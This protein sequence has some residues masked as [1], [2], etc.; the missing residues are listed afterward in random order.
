VNRA[1]AAGGRSPALAGGNHQ[2]DDRQNTTKEPSVELRQEC[3]SEE[4]PRPRKPVE[5]FWYS[6]RVSFSTL[7]V[8]VEWLPPRTPTALQRLVRLSWPINGKDL[9]AIPVTMTT[10]DLEQMFNHP[11]D[12]SYEIVRA[13]RIRKRGSDECK[14]VPPSGPALLEKE[15]LSREEA[16][17]A[18]GL[19]VRTVDRLRKKGKLLDKRYGRRVLIHRAAIKGSE[20]PGRQPATNPESTTSLPSS[21]CGANTQPP[22]SAGG[23]EVAPRRIPIRKPCSP[24]SDADERRTVPPGK[25]EKARRGGE[26]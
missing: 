12:S 22:H 14:P 24:E 19:S 18:L 9:W 7:L 8:N 15:Y 16:A 4:A 20:A 13:G 10:E 21:R 17:A 1:G 26:P 3:A 2:H 5:Y 23:D 6:P 11:W 25:H